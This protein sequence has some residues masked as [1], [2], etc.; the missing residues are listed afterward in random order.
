MIR[1]VAYAAGWLAGAVTGYVAGGITRPDARQP[2]LFGRSI[3]LTE[4]EA[5]VVLEGLDDGIAHRTPP[6]MRVNGDGERIVALRQLAAYAA[7]GAVIESRLR[8]LDN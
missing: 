5:T 1:R 3:A 8:A 6:S 2:Q 4:A 7:V